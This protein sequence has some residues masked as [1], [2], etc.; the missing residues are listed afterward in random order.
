MNTDHP[1]GREE[2]QGSAE[3]PNGRNAQLLP[4]DLHPADRLREQEG[5]GTVL[6]FVSEG[7]SGQEQ[8]TGNKRQ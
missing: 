6:E 8:Y 7:K 4:P 1:H 5:K 2:S 3:D